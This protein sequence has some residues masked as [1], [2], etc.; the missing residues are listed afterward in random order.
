M[1]SKQ[2]NK[3]Q[4][5]QPQVKTLTVNESETPSSKGIKI[6]SKLLSPKYQSQSSLGEQNRNSFSPKRVH[7]INTI[8]VLSK[9]D[10]PRETKIVKPDTKD[11]DHDT[12]VKFEELQDDKKEEKDDPEC[13]DTN[14]PSPPDSLIS[15]ITEKS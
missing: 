8:I 11:N 4:K 10:E 12:S 3:F 2:T 9:E 14:P 6:P 13:I 15:L 5:D 7:F 1:C